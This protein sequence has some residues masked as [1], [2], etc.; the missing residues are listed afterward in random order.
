VQFI[1]MRGRSGRREREEWRNGGRDEWRG[2]TKDWLE[3]KNEGVERG[4]E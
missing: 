1:K 2:G 4:E 3:E